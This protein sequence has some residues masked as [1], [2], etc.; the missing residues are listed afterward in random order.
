M[1][2]ITPE[3]CKELAKL[4][5]FWSEE[6][7]SPPCFRVSPVVGDWVKIDFLIKF[8]TEEEAWKF[9]EEFQKETGFIP[10]EEGVRYSKKHK[11]YVLT[12]Y[13]ER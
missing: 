9:S 6:G 3:E 2:K 7:F 5:A 8:P 4:I 1:A 11:A 10:D 13:H 12:W